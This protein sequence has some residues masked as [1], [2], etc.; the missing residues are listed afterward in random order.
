MGTIYTLDKIGEDAAVRLV[1]GGL[2]KG[3]IVV[4][5]TDT[6][7]GIS[8]AVFRPDTIEEVESGELPWIWRSQA[9]RLAKIKGR[10]GPFLVL[11]RDWNWA[12]LLTDKPIFPGALPDFGDKP[13]TYVLHSNREIVNPYASKGKIAI[14]VPRN[15][16]LERVLREVPMISSTS[17]NKPGMRAPAQFAEIGPEIIG[18]CDII[19]KTATGGSQASAVVD[20]TGVEPVVL[21]S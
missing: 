11:A 6:L 15:K 9:D 16:F 4:I 3:Q 21:R 20:V 13:T 7:F 2:Q 1:V 18:G 14:R 5:P 10:N 17:A 8:C 12:S 19:L